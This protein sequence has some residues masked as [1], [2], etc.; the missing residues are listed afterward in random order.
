ML[1]YLTDFFLLLPKYPRDEVILVK[2]NQITNGPVLEFGRLLWLIWILI[3]IIANHAMDW[4]DYFSV[5]PIDIFSVCSIHLNQ[6]ISGNWFDSICSALKFPSK[7]PP[8]SSL[9][10]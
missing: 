7:P 10:R 6:F 9:S 1:T 3:L 4:K 5:T 8:P 2:E